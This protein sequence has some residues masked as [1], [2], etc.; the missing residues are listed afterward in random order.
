M[1][2]PATKA[3]PTLQDVRAQVSKVTAAASTEDALAVVNALAADQADG[4]RLIAPAQGTITNWHFFIPTCFLSSLGV[5]E[6]TRSR[7]IE[8]EDETKVY[9][10]VEWMQTG[11]FSFAKGDT[12]YDTPKAYDDTPWSETLQHFK[13]CLRI[14]SATQGAASIRRIDIERS[15]TMPS[16]LNARL[17]AVWQALPLSVVTLEDAITAV[18]QTTGKG[19]TEE[20]LQSLAAKG[21]CRWIDRSTPRDPGSVDVSVWCP[22]ADRTA[23]AVTERHRMTQDDFVRLLI[24]GAIPSTAKPLALA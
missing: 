18:R 11:A 1:L 24:T 10:W 16:G 7:S 17:Q 14:D 9:R 20:S 15:S 5:R 3:F 8:I 23:H 6:G 22:T 4:Y 12:I 2:A 13:R 21:G 19:V